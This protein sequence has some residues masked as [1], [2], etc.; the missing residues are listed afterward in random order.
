MKKTHA[1]KQALERQ[2]S[3]FNNRCKKCPY[4][5]TY[6]Y[7]DDCMECPVRDELLEIGE[8]LMATVK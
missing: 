6:R 8:L 1:R 2:A 3:L 4:R 5:N 7:S